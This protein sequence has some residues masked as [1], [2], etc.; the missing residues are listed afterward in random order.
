[1][2]LINQNVAI[3]ASRVRVQP[4]GMTQKVSFM[5]GQRLAKQRAYEKQAKKAKIKLAVLCTFTQQLASMLEAGLALVS[6]LD[7]LQEQTEHPVFRIII[8]EV[9]NDVA[10]GTSFSE[11]VAKY[12]RAFP[13]LFI[14]MVEAGEAS[15]GLASLMGKVAV[16]FENSVRLAKKVKGAMVYPVSVIV[17]ATVLVCVLMIFVIPKFA[18]MYSDFGKELPEFTQFVIGISEFIQ[19]NFFYIAGA[20]F[21]IGWAIKHF[22]ATPKGRIIKDQILRHVMVVGSLIQKV[23]ISRF[24]RTYAILLRS[25]VPILRALEIVAKASG[26]S[27]IESACRDITRDISQGGQLSDTVAE[28][29]YFPPTVKHMARAGEQT[30]NVDGM[31]DKVA[32]FYDNEVNNTVDAL[33]SLM[34]PLIIV[35]LGVVVGGIVIAMFLPI[36]NMASAVG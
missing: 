25:G 21:G 36:F 10:S 34:Q 23:S 32:D 22:T 14:S 28:L 2:P 29:S 3:Q 33:T 15:G 20:V 4:K 16:Y 8:R 13:N 24:C 1:M 26:N 19:G 35:F 27:Y 6:A 5:E 12:P 7:A 30:G 17:L 11:A 18:E 9:K 31:M